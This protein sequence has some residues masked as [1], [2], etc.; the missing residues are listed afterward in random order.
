V[1]RWTPARSATALIVVRAGPTDV[2][3]ATVASTIRRRVSCCRSARRFS[4]YFLFMQT[5]DLNAVELLEANGLSFAFPLSSATGTASTAVVYMELEPGA[6][7]PSHTDSAEELLLV[8]DGSAEATVGDEEGRLE[9]G[10]RSRS[11]LPLPEGSTL[12]V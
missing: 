5:L 9:A 4:S 10:R 12:P 6:E 7:L 11:A 1:C 2:W 8:L 3:R